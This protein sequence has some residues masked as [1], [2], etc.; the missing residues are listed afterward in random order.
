MIGLQAGPL[1][2]HKEHQN[3]AQLTPDPLLYR[4]ST[5]NTTW[6]PHSIGGTSEEKIFFLS[7]R[8]AVKL[9]C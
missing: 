7:A 2:H 5:D 1:S 3:N 9:T 6:R 4:I 8:A